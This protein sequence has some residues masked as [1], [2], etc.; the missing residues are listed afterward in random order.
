[1]CLGDQVSGGGKSSRK[2]ASM[3]GKIVGAENQQTDILDRSVLIEKFMMSTQFDCSK[4]NES[5]NRWRDY[6]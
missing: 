1:M 6:V 2:P 3:P 4:L 5:M